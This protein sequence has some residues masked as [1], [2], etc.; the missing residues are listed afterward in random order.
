MIEINLLPEDRRKKQERFKRLDFSEFKLQDA[1]IFGMIGAVFGILIIFQIILVLSGIVVRSNLSSV[2]K[3]YNVILSQKK[4]ADTLKSEIDLVNKK[5]R[6]IDELM[7][8]RFSW[9]KKLGDLNYSM[10]PGVWLSE[11]DYADTGGNAVVTMRPD[12]KVKTV[13]QKVSA[14]HLALNGCAL[15][16]GGEGNAIIGKFIKSLKHNAAFYADFSDIQLGF[17]KS[18]KLKD[19]DVVNFKITCLFKEK[20]K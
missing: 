20:T 13:S 6:A 9:A 16:A 15:N 10:I 17:T 3:Q 19:Q 1:A 7:V 4:E 5:V 2:E 8:N 18:E 11:L 12:G 14:R